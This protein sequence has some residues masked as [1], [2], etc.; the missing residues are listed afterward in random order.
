MEHLIKLDGMLKTSSKLNIYDDNLDIELNHIYDPSYLNIDGI[1]EGSEHEDSSVQNSN[2][3]L[4]IENGIGSKKQSRLNYKQV[5]QN[6]DKIYFDKPHK[7]SN[8]LDILASY[9]KG[10]K[11]ICM[12]AKH[13]SEM[14]LNM[15]IIPAILLSTSA[16]ILATLLQ[17]YAWG[18]FVIS[19]VNGVISF[20]LALVNYY[21]L[22]A[23][24]ESYKISA[25][26]YDKLQ[27]MV[28][29]KSGAI[30]LFPYNTDSSNNYIPENNDINIEKIL[31][32]TI[33]DVQKKITDIKDTNQFVVPRVI[34]LRYPIIY[35][36]NI[37][38]IIKKIEDKK[39]RAITVLKNIKNEIRY[40]N[41]LEVSNIQLSDTQ[42]KRLIKLFNMKKDCIK[43]I[44]VLKSA[45][46]VVDQ[47]FLQEIENAEIIKRNWCRRILYKIFCCKEY[48][49]DLKEPEKLN[50]FVGGIMDPFKDK[51]EDDN[52]KKEE[53]E[54]QE[55]LKIKK[56]K[57]EEKIKRKEEIKKR[58]EEIN[59]GCW[60]LYYPVNDNTKEIKEIK[61]I[62]SN[63]T[64][65]KQQKDANFKNINT[66]P[67][68]NTQT[69]IPNSETKI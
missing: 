27:T 4:D 63:F 46:S 65:D 44:L 14:N 23:R 9:I 68:I 25:H 33:E 50:K 13:Y 60:P 52:K 1:I 49:L 32:K 59:I 36:T 24:S 58:N 64:A 17:W 6:I 19:T 2:M 5:E 51:E 62:L 37:F 69:K 7:Y 42:T 12:E 55:I 30:L 8:S 66:Q 31:I 38:S 67:N 16:T 53:E 40:Y 57:K 35:N 18:S 29:F 54:K 15:L 45:Y 56:M 10:Q 26:Q 61:E 28:E 41:N 39:K 34:R 3:N 47:M 43:D 21:K 11:I 20:L 48:N 22:D